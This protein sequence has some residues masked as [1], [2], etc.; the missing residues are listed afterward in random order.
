MSHSILV[1]DDNEQVREVLRRKL[2]SCG[3][4][5]CEAAD[6]KEA[7]R[8]LQTVPF[9]LIVT[10]IMM[11]E[12]DGLETICRIRKELPGLK[13][14]AISAPSNE[15]FLNDADRLGAARV[16]EKPLKLADLATA[17]EELL[18]E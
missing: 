12:Q 18:A 1:V 16:F 2:E 11:P 4:D 15:T 3:Y 10:D 14:I 7:M 5:V 6:G 9:D 8:A 13:I 17:V